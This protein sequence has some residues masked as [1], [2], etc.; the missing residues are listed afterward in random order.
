MAVPTGQDESFDCLELH[1]PEFL[2][3]QMYWTCRYNEVQVI[4]E[5][6]DLFREKK[7]NRSSRLTLRHPSPYYFKG[8]GPPLPFFKCSSLIYLIECPVC[9]DVIYSFCLDQWLYSSPGSTRATRSMESQVIWTYRF[10]LAQWTTSIWDKR[11]LFHWTS[12]LTSTKS[13]RYGN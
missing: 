5:V 6:S 4:Y 12:S 3:F 9:L 2:W 7:N 13:R 1:F 10:Y 8:Q 11:N